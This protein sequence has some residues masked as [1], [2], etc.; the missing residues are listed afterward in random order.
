MFHF[1]SMWFNNING[2]MTNGFWIEVV[3]SWQTLC[4]ECALRSN[5]DILN[6]CLWYKVGKRSILFINMVQ[7]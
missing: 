3:K 5:A 2:N 7:T 6:Y 1:E 4:Q